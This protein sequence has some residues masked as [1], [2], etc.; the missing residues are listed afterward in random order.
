M[1]EK[2]RKLS[3]MR[4]RTP[5]EILRAE[6]HTRIFTDES[7]NDKE[8]Y[9]VVTDQQSTRRRIKDHSSI[10]S[11]EQEATIGAIQKLP[12]TGVRGVIF[13]DSLSTMITASGNNHTKN[14]KT[15]KIRQLMDKRKGNVPLCWVP[16]LAEK[17]GNKEMDE[18]AK[19]A[20]DESIPNDEKYPPEN[21]SGWR[22]AEKRGGKRG[23]CNEIEKEEHG[24]K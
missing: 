3:K 20:L 18:E 21:L 10:S 14:P 2:W 19:R 8:G 12:T 17:T 16:G 1:K 5:N 7:K 22:A 11:A 4:K 15:R 24:S 9:T 6:F 23:E 13:T